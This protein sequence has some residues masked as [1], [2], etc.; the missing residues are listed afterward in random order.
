MKNQ[1]RSPFPAI[2]NLIFKF[3]L[4]DFPLLY[5]KFHQI[6][7]VLESSNSFVQTYMELKVPLNFLSG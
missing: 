1:M 5:F 7:I 3:F 2:E 6:S 4:R